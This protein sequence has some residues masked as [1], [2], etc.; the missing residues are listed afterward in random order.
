MKQILVDVDDVLLEWTQ[1]FRLWFEHKHDR[2]LEGKPDHYNL[3]RWTGMNDEQVDRELTEFNENSWEFGC[4]PPVPGAKAGVSKLVDLYGYRLVAITSC[5]TN[6]QTVALRKANLYH[7]FGDVF[8]AV[9]CVSLGESKATHL[10]DYKPTFWIEDNVSNAKMGTEYGHTPIVRTT[11]Q[12]KRYRDG[13]PMIWC[14]H[15]NEIIE[16]IIE[17]D[18]MENA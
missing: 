2:K 5:S 1:G 3:R 11:P 12:N 16:E 17:F 9:H 13:N 10:A 7:V 14:D 6:P 8:D 4:L 15:W 18:Y